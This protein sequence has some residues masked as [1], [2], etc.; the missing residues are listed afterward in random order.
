MTVD[1]RLL[2][3]DPEVAAV[4]LTRSVACSRIGLARWATVAGL[5]VVALAN[6]AF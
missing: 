3:F 6:G 4:P 2:E 5:G 1:S